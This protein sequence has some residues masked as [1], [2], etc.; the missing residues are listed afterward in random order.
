MYISSIYSIMTT[1]SIRF[2]RSSSRQPLYILTLGGEEKIHYKRK[3]TSRGRT[4]GAKSAY[5]TDPC[6]EE[7]TLRTNPELSPS[8]PILAVLTLRPLPNQPQPP[9]ALPFCGPPSGVLTGLGA[10]L[11]GVPEL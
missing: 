6:T 2:F 3:I 11:A 5:G 9:F 1:D 4:C 10:R 8:Y 7:H